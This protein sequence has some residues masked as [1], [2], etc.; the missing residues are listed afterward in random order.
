MVLER[1]RGRCGGWPAS[2]EGLAVSGWGWRMVTGGRCVV[3][4]CHPR[5]GV[6]PSK[7][8]NGGLRLL[9]SNS[10]AWKTEVGEMPCADG[11]VGA[12]HRV[13]WVW[14]L[15]WQALSD[16]RRRPRPVSAPSEA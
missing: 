2:R 9:C 10:G 4:I 11:A 3:T 13:C 7:G 8:Q 6:A 16:L 12:E 5:G 15:G 1:M 14:S